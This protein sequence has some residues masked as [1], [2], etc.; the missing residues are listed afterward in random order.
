YTADCS[1]LCVRISKIS[2]AGL[3]RSA[4]PFR[5][6]SLFENPN[7]L[8]PLEVQINASQTNRVG[9]GLRP[10]DGGK[11]IAQILSWLAI[12]FESKQSVLPQPG[13]GIEGTAESSEAMIGKHDQQRVLVRL[14]Q[15]HAQK[16]IAAAIVLFDPDSEF[17]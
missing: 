16:G 17:G 7:T 13:I 15:H 10:I 14:V 9:V 11:S 3:N 8:T 12:V 6:T 4:H 1:P 2:Q 5:F